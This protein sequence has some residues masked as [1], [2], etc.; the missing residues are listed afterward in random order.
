MH[1]GARC[2]VF[3]ALLPVDELWPVTGEYLVDG[4]PAEVSA[5]A[6]DAPLAGH[7]FKY[8]NR[9]FFPPPPS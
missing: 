2:Q 5:L 8:A 6:R 4:A 9:T 1:E 3:A 7:L